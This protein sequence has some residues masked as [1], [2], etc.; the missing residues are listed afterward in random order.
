MYIE[1]G[2]NNFFY[3]F[4]LIFE[5]DVIICLISCFVSFGLSSKFYF[6]L[7]MFDIYA[8][9]LVGLS[10]TESVEFVKIVDP[11]PHGLLQRSSLA[12]YKNLYMN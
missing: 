6:D 9:F 8:I 4:S 2:K 7:I 3:T 10:F 12:F 5:N 1:F 11:P